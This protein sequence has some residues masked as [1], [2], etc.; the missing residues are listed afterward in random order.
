M[1]SSFQPLPTTLPLCVGN[2]ESDGDSDGGDG[3][4]ESGDE[5][6][7][8]TEGE[9]AGDDISGDCG[10]IAGHSDDPIAD[11]TVADAVAAPAPV[12]HE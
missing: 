5:R 7:G 4:A 10:E 2:I 8:N 1:C 9:W 3:G 12:A 6:C 11:A